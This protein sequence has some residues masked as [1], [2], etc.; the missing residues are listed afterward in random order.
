MRYQIGIDVGGTF[1]DLAA[2]GERDG[3]VPAKV[4]STPHDEAQGIFDGIGRL[5]ETF[6]TSTRALLNDTDVILLGTTVVTN[7]MLEYSGAN[8]GLITT[9]GFRDIIDL[10]RGY[11]ESLFDIRLPAPYAIVPRQKRL[12]VTERIDCDGNVVIPLDEDEARHVVRRL[13]DLGVDSIAV[14]FLFGYVNPVHEQRVRE[15]IREEH[16]AAF[17]SLS[18]EVLPQ[19]REFERVSTTLVNAYV[20]PKFRGY[21]GR[22]EQRLREA[23]F[24]GDLFITQSN[25]GVMDLPFSGERGVEAI[26]SGPVGGV[27]AGVFN[28]DLS[29]HRNLITVDMG[30]TSYD[31]CLVRDSRPEIS[32]ES[33]VSRYRIATPMLDIHTIGAGGGSIAWVDEGGALKV[34]P[35]SAGAEPGPACYGRGG[36]EPTVTDADLVLGYIN[37]DFFLGG[38][39]RLDRAAAEAAIERQVA[40][41]LGMTVVQ[42]A[43][44][45]F[46]IVNNSMTNGIRY[47]SVARGH[48]PRDFALMA[49]GGAGAIHAGMQARDLG[50]KTILVPKR[51]S[52]FCAFGNLISDFKLSRVRTFIARAGEVDLEHL[53]DVL[54]QMYGEAESLLGSGTK[55]KE[56]VVQRFMDMR[57]LGQVHEVTVPIRSRTRRVTEVS[58]ATTIRDFH[59]QHEQLYTFKRPENPVEILNLRLD[60]IGVRDNAARPVSHAFEG[61]DP[62]RARKSIRPVYFETHGDYVDTPVYDG[63]LVQPGNL[64]P[65]PAI[66]EEPDTTIVVYPGQEA[67][68]D[69][70]Q[71]YVIELQ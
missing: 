59:D 10:R 23:G 38:R 33:W 52:V 37:P 9:K 13:K 53:N 41:P 68:L 70:Y 66:V 67:M 18:H 25:G 48:D 54:G 63:A 8:T 21:L 62:A 39:M 5:A 58:L 49:F 17:V 55:M 19:I 16:P 3:V 51:A 6:G 27:V 56:L 34:G 31:V 32:V 60:L 43:S 61:E 50:I 1:T 24:Q 2:I 40:Q 28:G 11:K 22:L 65:G 26:I 42:A 4:L 71:T 57:Y 20:S 15:I 29:G 64:I 44:G 14:A 46:R 47:V 35:R 36:A 7:T 30:G 69:H 12:G 45:I